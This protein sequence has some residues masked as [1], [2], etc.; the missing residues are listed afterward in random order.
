[1]LPFLPE[2]FLLSFFGRDNADDKRGPSCFTILLVMVLT[3]ISVTLGITVL[4]Q[5]DEIARL[6]SGR[7]Y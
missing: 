5:R 3:I 4:N 1:M 7:L 6:R 2:L